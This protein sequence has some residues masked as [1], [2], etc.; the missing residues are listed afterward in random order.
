MIDPFLIQPL[1]LL[2]EDQHGVELVGADLIERDFHAQLQR[3]PEIERAADQQSGFARL[4]RVE[5]LERA[6]V[7]AATVL[8]RVRTQPWIAQLLAPQSPV[9]Q[10]AE[11]RPL[12]P[13]PVQKFGSRSSWKPAS[14][15]SMAALTATA[16]WMIG[17]SPA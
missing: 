15:A 6:V 5:L 2:F 12:R 1:P 13:L 10:E 8:R 14:S 7:A 9:D 11:G 16:W 17:T 3:S 4:R